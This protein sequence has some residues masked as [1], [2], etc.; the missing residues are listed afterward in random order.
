RILCAGTRIVERDA[1]GVANEGHPVGPSDLAV[2]VR[3][4]RDAESVRDALLAAGVPAVV[5]GGSGVLTTDAAH[6]WLD[7]LRALEQPASTMRVRAAARGPFVGWDAT[8]L[9]TAGDE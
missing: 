4:H 6:D 9:A 2:L 5:H 7:L 3:R 1:D 8:Q